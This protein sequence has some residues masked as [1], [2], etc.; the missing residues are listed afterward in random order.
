MKPA[1]EVAHEFQ[2]FIKAVRKTHKA[3]AD[4]IDM[5]KMIDVD[6][7][8]YDGASQGIKE[9]QRA[10]VAWIGSV[11]ELVAKAIAQ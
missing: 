4:P 1:N 10:G 2:P 6:H 9:M 11:R 5:L 3:G 8:T 7:S